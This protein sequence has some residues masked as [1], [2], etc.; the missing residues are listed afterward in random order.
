MDSGLIDLVQR[1]CG[2]RR[3]S[4]RI[5]RLGINLG[6]ARSNPLR[7]TRLQGFRSDLRCPLEQ[8]RIGFIGRGGR[9]LK[10]GDAGLVP[11]EG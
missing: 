4:L 9:I 2:L 8:P 11:R 1:Q 6:P 5:D 3:R 7:H 10:R